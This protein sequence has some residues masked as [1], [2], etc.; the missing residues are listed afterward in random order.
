MKRLSSFALAAITAFAMLPSGGLR[1]RIREGPRP[2]IGPRCGQG[3]ELL[4]LEKEIAL[5]KQLAQEVERASQAGQRPGDLR[6]RQPVG[7]NLVRNA[8]RQGASPS[9]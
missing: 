3:R 9:R 8:G 5:G 6:I 2:R 7:Q 1:R 4:V